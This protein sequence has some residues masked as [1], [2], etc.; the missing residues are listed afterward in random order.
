V[1]RINSPT[2]SAPAL[3]TLFVLDEPSIGLHPRADMNAS[4]G[5]AA[6]CAMP[7]TL[8]VNTTRPMLAADRLIDIAPAL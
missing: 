5:D 3:Q 6:V 7:N 1:Q 4:P 2:H 8:V